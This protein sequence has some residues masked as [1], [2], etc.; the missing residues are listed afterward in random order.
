MGNTFC[1]KSVKGSGEKP[2]KS[3]IIAK[4]DEQ[5]RTAEAQ[6]EAR[7]RGVTLR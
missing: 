6:A 5:K 1:K 4:E 2:T 7:K 3:A